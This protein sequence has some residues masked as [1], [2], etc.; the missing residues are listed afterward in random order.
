MNSKNKVEA[1]NILKELS[2]EQ[3]IEKIII[4]P[5]LNSTECLGGGTVIENGII[6]HIDPPIKKQE[7]IWVDVEDSDCFRGYQINKELE[8]YLDKNSEDYDIW[9]DEVS[10]LKWQSEVASQARHGSCGI[11]LIETFE[12][13]EEYFDIN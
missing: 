7:Y 6:S 4:N 12:D 2:K 3:F 9:D 11:K 5:N 8:Q 10:F 13:L 1:F